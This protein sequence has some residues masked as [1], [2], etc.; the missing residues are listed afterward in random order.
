MSIESRVA[1]SKD[2]DE[3][4]ELLGL[5]D[6]DDPAYK[7]R[8]MELFAELLGP[9][10]AEPPKAFV[11][12]EAQAYLFGLETVRHGTHKGMSHEQ[13]YD[14]DPGFLDYLADQGM[15][16]GA[17]IRARRAGINPKRSNKGKDQAC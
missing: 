2:F 5:R 13:I 8:L 10:K 14:E 6:K 15:R 7:A 3:I 9:P 4:V 1:A 16:T 12:N 17:Y 11:M